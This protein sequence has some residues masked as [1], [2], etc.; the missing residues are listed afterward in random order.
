MKVG[1]FKR[2]VGNS[3][4]SV[5]S[6]NYSST[7]FNS[8]SGFSGVC[9]TEKASSAWLSSTREIFF[10]IIYKREIIYLETMNITF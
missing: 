5:D 9:D 4:S 6:A 2:V 1:T 3:A 7:L 10:L 8:F